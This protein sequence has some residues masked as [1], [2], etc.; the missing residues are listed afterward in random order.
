MGL[1]PGGT[2][3]YRSGAD[4]SGPP[5]SGPVDQTNS[6]VTRMRVAVTP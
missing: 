2:P 3:T 6:A 1:T 5:R 4:R